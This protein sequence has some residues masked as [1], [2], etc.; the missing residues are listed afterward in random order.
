MTTP[1]SP[2]YRML[3]ERWAEAFGTAAPYKMRARL[4]LLAVEWHAQMQADPQWRGAA[5]MQRVRRLLKP[6]AA[7]QKL[8]PGTRLIRQWQEKTYQVTVLEKG[9]EMDGMTFP[10]L[11]AIARHITGTRWSGPL[12]F[13]LRK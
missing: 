5:G 10:S 13:G 9:F 11:T 7:A 12:F 2:E 1:S 4:M 8:S 6:G 3:Q